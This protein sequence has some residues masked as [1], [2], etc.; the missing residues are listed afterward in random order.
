MS[1]RNNEDRLGAKDL[2]GDSPIPHVQQD[3]TPSTFSF[4]TPTEFV[5]LP[6][7]GKYYPEGHPLH[8]VD[9]VEIKHMTAK[10]EDILTSR[11]LLKKGLAIDRLLQSI[12]VDKRI[13]PDTLLIGDK[14]AILVMTRAVGYGSDYETRVTCPVC[15]ENTEF[16]FDLTRVHASADEGYGEHSDSISETEY[17]FEITVPK[18]GV[19][20]GA[21]LLTG[22]DEKLLVEAAALKRKNRL[23]ESTLTDQFRSF[24]VSV[25]GYTD[26]KSINNF[27]E[28]MPASDSRF[29]RSAYEKVVPNID[30]TQEFAC[31]SCS[32][33]GSMEVPLNADFFWP[34]R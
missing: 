27:I 12:L 28:N 24:I 33:E 19:K 13:N 9:T 10:E 18:T 2:G 14:N 3:A 15:M 34:K 32:Y 17:G 5:D 20:V 4:V 23:P 26:R 8:N 30:M 25:N 29:L 11:S 1:V 21:K 6:S 7:K 31:N 22:K 16:P